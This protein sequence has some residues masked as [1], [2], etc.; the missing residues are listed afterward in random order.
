[1]VDVI[2]TGVDTDFVSELIVYDVGGARTQRHKWM[3][4]FDDSWST[5]SGRGTLLT[6]P[7]VNVVVFLAPISA[8]DQRLVEDPSINRLQDTFALWKGAD[9]TCLSD[10]LSDIYC[11]DMPNKDAS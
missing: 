1:M 6:T 2:A 7:I 5:H 3:P 9:P 4:F 10:V 8:F 11:R